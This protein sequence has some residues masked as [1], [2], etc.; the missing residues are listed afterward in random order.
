[1]SN[2]KQDYQKPSHYTRQA[3]QPLEY[4][5]ANDLGFIEGNVVKYVTRHK[6]KNG[7]E[8][9]EKARDY[10]DELIKYKKII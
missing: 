10:I 7:V 9:L 5:M 6:D 1:M 8:D 3:I 4:I 2:A